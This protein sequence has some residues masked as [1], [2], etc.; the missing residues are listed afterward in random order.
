MKY[1]T[2]DDDGRPTAFFSE[3][4][5]GPRDNPGTLIPTHAIAISDA[6]WLEF[7]NNDG[8]RKW[9]NG[10]VVVCEPLSSASYVPVAISRR[11]FFQMLAKQGIISKQEALDAIR[12]GA[13]PAAIQTMVD[14]IEDEDQR[15]NAEMLLSGAAEFQRSHPLAAQIG[16]LQGMS[17]EQIDDFFIGAGEL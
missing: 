14:E 17:I 7:L 4:I 5:H 1:A 10:D 2:F 3:D 6:Q 8:F 16:A 9:D 11:Q 15:F 12:I 13:V